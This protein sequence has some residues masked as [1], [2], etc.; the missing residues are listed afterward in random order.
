MFT[1]P[2]SSEVQL[3]SGGLAAVGRDNSEGA[4]V[5]EGWS[6][7]V[8]TGSASFNSGLGRLGFVIGIA[9]LATVLEVMALALALWWGE[10][11]WR[12]I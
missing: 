4:A 1:P 5:E 2:I 3:F 7:G 10:R 6:A 12:I 8:V 9:D 11:D